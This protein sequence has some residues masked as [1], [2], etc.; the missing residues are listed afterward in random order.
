MVKIGTQCVHKHTRLRNRIYFKLL[1]NMRIVYL[2]GKMAQFKRL[3][4]QSKYS[5][6][7]PT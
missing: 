4:F 7:Q 5:K 6:I 3:E 2:A 1:R